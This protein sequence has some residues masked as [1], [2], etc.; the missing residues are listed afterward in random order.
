MTS[1]LALSSK[2]HI[3]QSSVLCLHFSFLLS[4]P[5]SLIYIPG[6][7]YHL[8]VSECYIFIAIPVVCIQTPSGCFH[9]NDPQE[10]QTQYNLLLQL[11]FHLHNPSIIPDKLGHHFSKPTSPAHCHLLC[12]Q[13]IQTPSYHSVFR[14]GPSKQKSR[15]QKNSHYS[16]T[17]WFKFQFHPTTY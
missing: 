7:S 5:N 1:S 16:Q 17:A 13:D 15:M 6:S 10:S 9:M 11:L 12:T 2:V 8:Y 14:P 3:V 4:F